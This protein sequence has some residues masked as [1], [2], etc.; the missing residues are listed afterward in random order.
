[1]TK[2]DDK[3]NIF[4][5]VRELDRTSAIGF[6]A[7]MLERQVPNFTLFCALTECEGSEQMIKALNQVWLAYESALVRRKFTT[8]VSLLRDKVEV[9][10]PD[11]AD[12]DNFGVYP[13]IDCAMAMVAT[14]NLI[15]REDEA[16]AVAVSKLSQGTVESVIIATEGEIENSEIKQHPLMQREIDYQQ[17]ILAIL[18]EQKP[19]SKLLKSMALEDGASNIGISED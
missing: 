8:N 1:M 11:S 15:D 16:G 13:A 2:N 6:C 9:V 12:Y 17:Q 5:R 18:S 4:G 10:T 3:L 7:A 19:T 14:L